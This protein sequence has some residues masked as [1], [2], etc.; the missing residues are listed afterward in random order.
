MDA[1]P[2]CVIVGIKE[3]QRRK[4]SAQTD[5]LLILLRPGYAVVVLVGIHHK[6]SKPFPASETHLYAG[7]SFRV[8]FRLLFLL[9]FDRLE[10]L[11]HLV[12]LRFAVL[13]F[14]QVH[15]RIAF[16]RHLPD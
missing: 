5:V 6:S 2:G 11:L 16:P 4:L 1:A 7:S 10:E 15:A 3:A 9:A 8:L 12:L 13:S 14:L